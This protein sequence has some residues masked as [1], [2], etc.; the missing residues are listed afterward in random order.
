[1][2]SPRSTSLLTALGLFACTQLALAAPVTVDFGAITPH[3]RMSG[4]SYTD[5]ATGLIANAFYYDSSATPSATW[6]QDGTYLYVR[7]DNMTTE[8]GLGVCNPTEVSHG[9]CNAYPS[10]HTGNVTEI[11]GTT[12]VPELIRLTLPSGYTWASLGLSSLD[13]QE[14]GRLIASNVADPNLLDPTNS[15]NPI[16]FVANGYSTAPSGFTI[17]PNPATLGIGSS[18]AGLKYLFIANDPT[19]SPSGG[20]L[21][22]SA[23]LQGVPEPGTLALLGLGLVGCDLLRRS[24]RA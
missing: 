6:S 10:Y 9:V 4:A 15:Y 8:S 2:R 5:A 19:V 7:N 22:Q 21:L 23:T 1:M 14:A 11:G 20:F 18:Y 24:R 13:H 16:S 17:Y 12:G 3:G